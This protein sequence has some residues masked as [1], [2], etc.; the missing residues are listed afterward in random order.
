MLPIILIHIKL[1]YINKAYYY[2]ENTIDYECNDWRGVAYRI[3]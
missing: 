2:M 3:P 1:I